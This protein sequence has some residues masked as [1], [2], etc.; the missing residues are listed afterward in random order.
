MPDP[1]PDPETFV[2]PALLGALVFVVLAFVVAGVATG[3]FHLP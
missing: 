3:T 1:L 2:A